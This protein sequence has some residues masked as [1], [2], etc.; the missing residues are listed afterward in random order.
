MPMD[1]MIATGTFALVLAVGIVLMSMG[2]SDGSRATE[3]LEEVTRLD[4]DEIGEG[5]M[6]TGGRKT[7]RRATNRREEILEVFYRIHLLNRLE[8]SMW[9]AG[10][11]MRVSEM[12]RI[13]VLMF[14][15]GF[16]VAKFVLHDT[17]IALA[18]AWRWARRRL[19]TFASGASVAC[20]NL[21]SSC[22]PRS[23]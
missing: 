23:T 22:R 14:G 20:A 5:L 12:L 19:S 6:R 16:T 8:E 7:R 9:Q 10:L 11:Y 15:L 3:L 1:L 13:I 18:S 2:R 21:R 17:I 4:I